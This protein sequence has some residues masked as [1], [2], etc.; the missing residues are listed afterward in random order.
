MATL[1]LVILLGSV[2]V[3]GK[4]YKIATPNIR[5]ISFTNSNGQVDGLF[6]GVVEQ[7]LK[8]NHIEYKYVECSWSRCIDLLK[9]GEVDIIPGIIKN[10]ERSLEFS[11]THSTLSDVWGEVLSY[12]ENSI[13]DLRMLEGKRVGVLKGVFLND[14]FEGILAVYNIDSHIVR[15]DTVDQLFS[16][17]E[18]RKVD[19]IVTNNIFMLGVSPEFH[20]YHTGIVFSPSYFR[21]ATKKNTNRDLLELLDNSLHQMKRDPGSSYY[22]I[23]GRF[24]D[25]FRHSGFKYSNNG[26]VVLFFIFIFTTII[27][28]LLFAQRYRLMEISALKSTNVSCFKWDAQSN[29]VYFVSNLELLQNMFQKPLVDANHLMKH[30][31]PE[32]EFQVRQLFREMWSTRKQYQDVEFRIAIHGLTRWIHLICKVVKVD[33]TGTPT[34]ITGMI[35]DITEVKEKYL[36]EKQ[37]LKQYQTIF[38]TTNIGFWHW[39]ITEGT[40]EVNT[41]Y[42]T[43]LGYSPM[44]RG[45]FSSAMFVEDQI[46]PDDREKFQAGL[47]LHLAG[48]TS[49]FDTEYRVKRYDGSFSWVHS[50]GIVL[51]RSHSGVATSMV[52]ININIDGNKMNE[53]AILQRERQLN[54]LAKKLEI[55]MEKAQSANRLKSS[56]LANM[57]HEIR[58]PLNAVIG[59]T[60]VL[61]ETNL[62]ENQ[63]YYVDIV[64]QAGENLLA[65]INDILDTSK[66]EAGELHL[67]SKEFA[68]R[69]VTSRAV[70]LV[71][72]RF[73]DKDIVFSFDIS[74]DVPSKIIG[75]EFR[76]YQVL[77][78]L[79]NN[80]GKFTTV[81]EVHLSL[82][83]SL[84]GDGEVLRFDVTDTGIG[85]PKDSLDVIFN[86]FGQIT[87]DAVPKI[88]G[89]GLGLSISRQLVIMMG[90]EIGVESEPEKGSCFFFTIDLNVSEEQPESSMLRDSMRGMT[91]G[92]LNEHKLENNLL[93]SRYERY[94]CRIQQFNSFEDVNFKEID[95]LLLDWWYFKTQHLEGP[96]KAIGPKFKDK[97]IMLQPVFYGNDQLNKIH[98]IGIKHYVH[99]PI[100]FDRLNDIILDR[101][102]GA[103]PARGHFSDLSQTVHFKSI[104]IVD[105]SDANLELMKVFVNNICDEF[106]CAKNGLAAFEAVKSN[107]FDL[108]F[109]DI[110]MPTMDGYEATKRIR[111]HENRL[112]NS[113][114]TIIALTAY[115]LKDEVDKIFASGFDDYLSKPLKKASLFKCIQK[116]N[117]AA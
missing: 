41:S 54:E 14:M 92:I 42:V 105:D 17:L 29:Q 60:D 65:L 84:V 43:M 103:N 13:T 72:F 62:D 68:V 95:F 40:M 5:P 48:H 66:I 108:V 80:A 45:R 83:R 34:T 28:V 7:I 23:R 35:R 117:K 55:N 58:T 25:T 56:F 46:H 100:H 89:T 79:L 64:S 112:G 111:D 109:M 6:S 113:P 98:E 93:T 106:V 38:E 90:G 39:D 27:I 19:A 47:N 3:F 110:Q 1:L 73:K 96:V 4:T 32:D 30:V 116:Y 31:H 8:D 44:D 67:E 50:K 33:Q 24:L 99:R 88:E 22:Q 2:S 16:S 52:G 78:N 104:L 102:I 82:K 21:I 91:V 77:V 86:A 61:S 94:G 63:K 9:K 114:T 85:I 53:L 20:Y 71:A 70:D 107:K 26:L 115:A 10:S 87:N 69:E 59:M 36:H 51:E 12:N 101:T 49:I 75:D 57:S 76:L 15:F 97:L 74:E 37:V 81:G 18:L 11:F